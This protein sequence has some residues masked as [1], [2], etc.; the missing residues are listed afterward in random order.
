LTSLIWR[1]L[2]R[3]G[4]IKY[5]YLLPVYRALGLLPSQ[6]KSDGTLKPSRT[7][8]GAQALVRVLNRPLY[9]DQLGALTAR[10]EKSKGTVIFLPSVGWDIVNTQRT[11]HLAR[12]FAR[13]GYVAIFDSSNSYDDVSGFKEVE[14]NL[15]LFRGSD[16][17]LPEIPD[18][19]LW[20]FTY[21]FD[22]RDAYTSSAITV[23]DW[24]DE[25][26]VFHFDRAFLLR[27]HERALKEAT[28]VASVARRLHDRA[29]ATRP[30]AVYLPNGVEYDHFANESILAPDDSDIDPAWLSGKPVAGYYGALAEWFDYDLLTEVARMRPDWNFLLIGPKYDNSLSERGRLMLKRPNVRWI[31]PRDYQQ[32]PGYLRIFDVAM[33]PFEI[34]NI[35]LATSPLKLFEYFAGGKPVVATPMPEC[36]VFPQVNI[37]RTAEEFSMA[38]DA[39]RL[40]G[41]DQ[42][43]REVMRKLG[44]DNS[45]NARVRS[46][47]EH[48]RSKSTTRSGENGTALSNRQTDAAPSAR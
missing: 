45:W 22:R 38:M 2:T 24:I 40:Q 18:P 31:G 14:P 8:R 28:V 17:V 13:Q 32:L 20:S 19:V 10:L 4:R 42:Q 26:E 36:Q 43:F 5:R 39:A 47:L 7:L 46:I 1:L 30:D 48:L 6:R 3:Y 23:Y 29:S 44:R 9:L 33:I 12:E 41:Q 27:N 16:D 25:L 11:H 21:N 34:N 15:F 37:A 35:T